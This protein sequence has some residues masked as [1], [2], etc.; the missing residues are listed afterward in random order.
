M[1]SSAGSRN[2]EHAAGSEYERRRVPEKALKG[3][4]AFWGMYAGEHTAGTE[5]MIGPLF[6]A[7]GADAASL[8]FGL[9]IGNL[10]AVLT[11]RY[12]TTDDRLQRTAHA[13]LQARADRRPLPREA[14]QPRQRPALLL[15]GRRDD[16]RLG[17]GR[18]GRSSRPARSRCPPSPTRCRPARPGSSPAWRSARSMTLVAM[19]GYGVVAKVGHFAAP[20]MFLVFVACGLVTLGRLGTTDLWALLTPTA[21]PADGQKIS[22]LGVVSLLLVLQRRDAP[23]HERPLGAPLRPQALG[24]LG[25]GRGHVPR[26]L[27]RL[28]LRGAAA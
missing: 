16:H 2:C 4:A 23:G 17:H 9:L 20:W 11:W 19:R 27:R 22:F 25:P 21:E 7:W 24:G 28:D 6:V 5:F 1:T 12:L 15:P 10:L 26:P 13:L 3:P 14:L 8:I 18:R